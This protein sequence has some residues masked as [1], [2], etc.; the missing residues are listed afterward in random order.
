[1]N[2]RIKCLALQLLRV[3]PG[4]GRAHRALQRH[5]TGRYFLNLTE[6]DLDVHASHVANYRRLGRPGRALEF[7]AGGHLLTAL[8]LSAAGA[9]EILALDIERLATVERV[10]HVIRQLAQLRLPGQWTE[11]T[12]LGEDLARRHRIRYLAPADCRAT[13]LPEGSVDFVYSTSTLEHITEPDIVAILRECVRV[14]SSDALF[15]F[16]IDYRDH[17]AGF[18]RSITPYNFYRY[19]DR[20]WSKYSPPQ[21]FQNRL[22]HCDYVRLF[23]VL[24]VETV[25]AA[26]HSR[27]R[28]DELADIPLSCRF[29]RYP[30]DDLL[31][32]DGRFL[33]AAH[34]RRA[35]DS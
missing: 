14:S 16:S 32:H 15:S 35:I 24:G 17:Y 2:W 7:G 22:R 11:V 1:M 34:R 19:S 6:G 28:A 13:G 20:Q 33:L 30:L 31:T 9:R 4:G 26:R 21:H 29:R 25:S 12:D 23:D 8:M 18:D 10:N 27:G 3:A 5:V